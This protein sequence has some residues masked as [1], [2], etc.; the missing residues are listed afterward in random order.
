MRDTKGAAETVYIGLSEI[1]KNYSYAKKTLL[2]DG[3]T[4]Y[5]S[6]IVDK[7]RVIDN[8]AVF[9]TINTNP[10]PI[11]SYIVMNEFDII[12]DIKE[13]KK[14]SDNANTGAYAF[15]DIMQ[16][17]NY[18]KYV[19]DNDI[20]FNNEC[21]TS[22]IIDEM[23]KQRELFNGI[24]VQLPEQSHSNIVVHVRDT[25]CNSQCSGDA[26]FVSHNLTTS[27]I[28]GIRTADCVPLLVASQDSVALVHAGWRGLANGI[29][30]K[31]L[32][33]F[34]PHQALSVLI[35][36]CGGKE[37]YQVEHEVLDAIG[38]TVVATSQSAGK[39][40]LNMPATAQNQI[41]ACHPQA[42][43]FNSS[44]CTI[45][46]QRFNSYR[47]D[48]ENSGRNLSFIELNRKGVDHE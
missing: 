19:V 4:F 43:V 15:C 47:R 29:I 39:Y 38:S 41:L 36:P 3:D 8:N 34:K 42:Q 27:V 32:S 25:D 14:I 35:G 30:S 6:N 26:L 1:I 46:D 22:C 11:F 18:S 28:L 17:Y 12:N 48:H 10:N 23:I 9:Y 20:R 31:T 5:T 7:F 2:I 13:K 37:T 21:Y 45:T 44:I 33:L 24:K 16:L 40:L